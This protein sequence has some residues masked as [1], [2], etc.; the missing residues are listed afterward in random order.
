MGSG[1]KGKADEHGVRLDQLERRDV[2]LDD[3]RTDQCSAREAPRGRLSRSVWGT[4]PHN[5]LEKRAESFCTHLAEDAVRVGVVR[6]HGS[7]RELQPDGK[8]QVSVRSKTSRLLRGKRVRGKH[9]ERLAWHRAKPSL[10]EHGTRIVLALPQP[11]LLQLYPP[12]PRP[13]RR[14][15]SLSEHSARPAL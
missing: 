6:G 3:L 14:L 12:P 5:P 9:F 8:V 13:S 4:Q 11:S 2:A 10:A 7:A 15:R 1:E